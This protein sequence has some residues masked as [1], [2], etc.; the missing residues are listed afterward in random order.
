MGFFARARPG[1]PS[2]LAL[3]L[4]TAGF[5]VGAYHVHL[6]LLGTLECPY[7]IL[8]IG[9]APQQSLVGLGIVLALV[10]AGAVH[11]RRI[12]IGRRGIVVG[13]L[14]IGLAAAAAAIIS[15]PPMPPPPARPHETP[16]DMCRP[17][18]RTEP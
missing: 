2:L 13:A 7:G 10:T 11:A 14:A 17:P 16:L 3:P 8:G 18:Y 5:G 4:A 9:T 1:V 12:G 15:A 6:E